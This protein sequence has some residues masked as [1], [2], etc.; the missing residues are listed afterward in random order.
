MVSETVLDPDRVRLVP[1]LRATAVNVRVKAR[2]SLIAQ[3]RVAALDQL[4]VHEDHPDL[5]DRVAVDDVKHKTALVNTRAAF[6]FKQKIT[7]LHMSSRTQIR[8]FLNFVRF[9]VNP[10]MTIRGGNNNS[11]RSF[12]VIIFLILPEV[13]T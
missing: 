3:A 10:G 11:P 13:Y 1:T 7:A 9:R 4:V 8:D 12:I 5:E 2:A 6:L